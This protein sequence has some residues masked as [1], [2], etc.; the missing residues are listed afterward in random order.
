MGR[1]PIV[2]KIKYE[3]QDT[4]AANT[5][6][7]PLVKYFDTSLAVSGAVEVL[8][9]STTGA[10]TWSVDVYETYRSPEEPSTTF[11]D[12]SAIATATLSTGNYFKTEFTPSSGSMLRVVLQ[13]LEGGAG[14]ASADIS[15]NIITRPA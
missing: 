3:I 10:G 5:I 9:H 1:C 11:A 6:K 13:Y 7:I 2:Q 12:T 4:G 8:K 14:A 15:V